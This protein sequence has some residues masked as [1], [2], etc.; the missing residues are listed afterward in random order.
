MFH[1]KDYS[2]PPFLFVYRRESTH[3]EKEKEDDEE[4]SAPISDIVR[5]VQNVERESRASNFS[6]YPSAN[7]KVVLFFLHFFVSFRG[8]FR[9]L[10][11]SIPQGRM[12][13]RRREEGRG[14]R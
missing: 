4:T 9:I 8:H 10:V 11:A 14:K 13:K 6:H 5:L 3:V 2:S 1:L 12:R 7:I